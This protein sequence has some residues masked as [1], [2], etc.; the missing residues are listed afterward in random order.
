MNRYFIK[1]AKRHGALE[2]LLEN[3]RGEGCDIVELSAKRSLDESVFFVRMGVRETSGPETL[4]DRL[5]GLDEISQVE[6]EG[7][8][9]PSVTR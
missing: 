6:L 4:L 5:A 2:R 8:P 3:V 1:I 7:E 9:R